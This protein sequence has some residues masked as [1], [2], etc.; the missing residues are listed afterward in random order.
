MRHL[1]LK[2][3]LGVGFGA[4]VTMIIFIGAVGYYS[5]ERLIGASTDVTFSL[6]QRA[7]ATS[8]E[9]GI[10]KQIRGAVDFV[11][12]GNDASLRQYQQD[13]QEVSQRLEEL[14]RVLSSE[15]DKALLANIRTSTDRIS[16]LTEKEISLRRQSR[17]YE[18][19]TMA[20]GPEITEAVKNV[21]AECNELEARE[22][23]LVQDRINAE[24]QTES[25]AN[26]ITL[27]LVASGVFLGIFTSL[28]IVRS[29][30]R[31]VA[32]MLRMIQ[33]VSAKNLAVE[34]VDVEFGDEIGEAGIALNSMRDALR[35]M[36]RSIAST[37]EQL[38]ATSE[39]ISNG[40]V[41]SAESARLQAD[42]TRQVATAMTEMSA[43][44]E[45]VSENSQTAADS[46]TKPPK[47][48]S[49]AARW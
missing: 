29:I 25:Q 45:Q 35:D 12:N 40:A 28:L 22:D 16:A 43:T 3:K 18:A 23:R 37:A 21:V 30:S 46:S 13:K 44:V 5:T 32:G 24:Y 19:N 49:R 39:E 9:M 4:L 14:G 42:Q 38:A 36:V 15:K 2:A 48:H 26:K 11:F 41:Q 6:K 10:R 17:S 1:G 27:L 34:D 8:I 47:P 31:G 20:F 7:A 33:E